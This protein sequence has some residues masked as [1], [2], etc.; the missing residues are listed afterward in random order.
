MRLRS[1][2]EQVVHLR[3]Y[4][5][6]FARNEELITEYCHKYSPEQ[7]EAIAGAAGLDVRKQWT[8]E[9]WRFSVQLLEPGEGCRQFEAGKDVKPCARSGHRIAF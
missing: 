8:D 9:Q 6:E 1:Q 4:S 5:I 7:F 2:C 3:G